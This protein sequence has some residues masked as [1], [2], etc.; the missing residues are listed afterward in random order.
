MDRVTA[1]KVISA[2]LTGEGQR[3]VGGAGGR[4]RGRY[5]REGEMGASEGGKEL[6]EGGDGREERHSKKGMVRRLNM[7]E[8]EGNMKLD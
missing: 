6:D 2:D 7:K 5:R 8:E 1:N 4:R 3:R